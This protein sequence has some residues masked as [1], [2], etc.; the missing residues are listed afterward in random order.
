MKTKHYFLSL[1]STAVLIAL[2]V[3]C[4]ADNEEQQIN[5]PNAQTANRI[6]TQEYN[7]P[8][9]KLIII[10]NTDHVFEKELYCYDFDS[11][12]NLLFTLSQNIRISANTVI[13]LKSFNSTFLEGININN[14]DKWIVYTNNTISGVTGLAASNPSSGSSYHMHNNL[15]FP[16]DYVLWSGISSALSTDGLVTLNIKL[17]CLGGEVVTNDDQSFTDANGDHHIFST[18]GIVDIFGNTTITIGELIY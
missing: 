16:S 2:F 11:N 17:D 1:F 7:I 4:S 18:K 3:S 12:N 9:G 14:D 5:K 10:N 13:T 8:H 15:D 6:T